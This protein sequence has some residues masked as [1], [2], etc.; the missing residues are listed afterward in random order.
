M[1]RLHIEKDIF[2]RTS[3]NVYVQSFSP[4]QKR[5]I[6]LRK[7]AAIVQIFLA[8]FSWSCIWNLQHILLNI[9]T[10]EYF[11]TLWTLGKVAK[12]QFKPSLVIKLRNTI[13]S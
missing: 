1:R 9:L 7:G 3:Q 8:L 5:T 11:F 2:E 12:S 6:D 4:F 10:C 13:W